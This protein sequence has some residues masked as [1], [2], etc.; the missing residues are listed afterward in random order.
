VPDPPP[1]AVPVVLLPACPA[2]VV[3]LPACPAGVPLPPAAV[4]RRG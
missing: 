3:L 1:L 4:R 2:G